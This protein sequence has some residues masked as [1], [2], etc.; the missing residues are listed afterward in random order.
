V[1]AIA[2]RHQ[3]VGVKAQMPSLFWG[4]YVVHQN[5]GT[6][7]LAAITVQPLAHWVVCPYLGTAVAATT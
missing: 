4:Y 2:Q 7:T 3:I 5:T 1:A 6:P